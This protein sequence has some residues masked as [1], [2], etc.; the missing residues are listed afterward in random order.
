[1][2]QARLGS[3]RLPGKVLK[4]L[5]SRTVI[6]HLLWRLDRCERLDAVVVATSDLP[7]D[8]ALAE[9]LARA[10]RP[11]F[12]G[13]EQ[14]VLARFAGA[15]EA[16]SAEVVVRLTGDCPLIDATEVDRVV[17]VFLDRQGGERPAEFVRNQAGK[18]RKIP[19]GLDVEVMTATLLQRAH[20][21]ATQPGEREHVTPWMYAGE[22]DVEQWVTHPEGD[23]LS[24]LRLT[25]D[26]PQDLAALSAVVA[27]LGDDVLGSAA[28]Q[29]LLTQPEV[30]RLQEGINQRG[31]LDAQTLRRQRAEGRV[32]FA[33]VDAGPGVGFGHLA[34]VEALL[35]AWTSLGGAAIAHGAGLAGP[36]A[37]RMRR[38]GV[39]FLDH[40][41]IAALPGPGGP[42]DVDEAPLDDARRTADLAQRHHAVAVLVDGYP[43]RANW[44]RHLSER[45]PLVAIDDMATFSL[46]ADVVVNQ[47]VGF[48]PARYTWESDPRGTLLCGAPYVLLRPEFLTL[49]PATAAGAARV[50]VTFGG[51]DLGGWTLPVTRE[52]LRVFAADVQVDVLVGSGLS[53]AV[54]TELHALAEGH[55]NLRVLQGLTEVAAWMDGATLALCAA[56][57]TCWELLSRGV[58]PAAVALADNQ[59]SVAGGIQAHGAGW[60]PDGEPTVEGLVNAAAK[61]LSGGPRLDQMRR[62]GAG[63]IDGRG[64]W[65]VIDATLD[66]VERR[67]A[68]RT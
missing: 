53:P 26:T 3:S 11:C 29:W 23:D 18:V 52:S 25:V 42:D 56:G 7:G 64:V 37:E 49:K 1:M 50:L 66:A 62:A 2:V 24:A 21:E 22:V 14:D 6:D 38:H 48:D 47:N 39:K 44:Q 31:V 35:A 4:P 17:Q 43:F 51:A 16:Y 8:D 46:V 36:V 12:R 15:A 33:R 61:L 45:L 5:G 59:L 67:E 13:S 19:H 58:V 54:M 27:A 57:S 20:R 68:R 60:V 10:E 28:C 30:R 41:E 65:R 40:A 55:D 32:L 63:L 34:R 9:H